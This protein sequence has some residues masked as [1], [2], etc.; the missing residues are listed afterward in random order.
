MYL[1]EKNIVA[2]TQIKNFCPERLS[3]VTQ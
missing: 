1:Q 3:Y 2:D